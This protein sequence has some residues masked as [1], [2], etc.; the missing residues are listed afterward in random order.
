LIIPNPTHR[1]PGPKGPGFFFV[2]EAIFGGWVC[3]WLAQ[4]ARIGIE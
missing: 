4:W 2:E 3:C 1:E